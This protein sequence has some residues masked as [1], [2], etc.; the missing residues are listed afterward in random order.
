[1]KRFLVTQQ[2]LDLVSGEVVCGS[3]GVKFSCDCDGVK[4]VCGGGVKMDCSGN[5][6]VLRCAMKVLSGRVDWL[7]LRGFRVCCSD[8]LVVI[9]SVWLLRIPCT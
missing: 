4:I 9:R 6:L 1:M 5:C 7:D 3:G 2:I 8:I